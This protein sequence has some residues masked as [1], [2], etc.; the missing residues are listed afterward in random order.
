MELRPGVHLFPA[1]LARPAQEELLGEVRAM[2]AAA[3]LLRPEMPGT[4][5]PF[6]VRMTNG[7]PLGWVSDRKGYRYQPTHPGTGAPWP[8]I[9]ARLLRLWEEVADWPVPPDACLV[10]FYDEMA[11]LGLHQDRDEEDLLAPVLSVS[12]GDE[13]VFR[14]GGLE[15][16]DPTRSL[17]LRSGDVLVLGG[18]GRLCFHGVDRILPGSSTLLPK[19]GRINLTLRRVRPH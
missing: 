2:V 9:P 11:R 7:G 13:A 5:R 6:S 18:A 4:G 8:P 12:L 1:H 15:R 17:R 3:P 14:L 19:G 16:G 10:N